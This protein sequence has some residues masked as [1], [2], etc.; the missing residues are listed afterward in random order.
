ME[1]WNVE[2]EAF[3][4]LVQKFRAAKRLVVDNVF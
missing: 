2:G 1:R 3:G 4:S